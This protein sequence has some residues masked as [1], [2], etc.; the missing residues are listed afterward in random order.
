MDTCICMAES[1]CFPSE[2]ITTLLIGYQIRS[3]QSLSRV[4]LFV[5]PWIAVCQASLSI[6]NSRSSLRHTSIESVMPSSPIYNKKLKKK[7]DFSLSFSFPVFLGIS[8]YSLPL[9]CPFS[10]PEQCLDTKGIRHF[11]LT[12]KKLPHL[13]QV[14]SIS[15]EMQQKSLGIFLCLV[16]SVEMADTCSSG[17]W[18]V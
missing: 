18:T 11:L 14:A 7:K 12:Q 10:F 13:Y 6:T 15:N 9:S 2:T 5:T 3:N 4:R 16:S 1:L 8:L 17:L